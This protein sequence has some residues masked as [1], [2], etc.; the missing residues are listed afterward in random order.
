MADQKKLDYDHCNWVVEGIIKSLFSSP[1]LV[2]PGPDGPDDT[3][4][5][6][7]GRYVKPGGDIKACECRVVFVF[8][9]D[10]GLALYKK[11]EARKTAAHALRGR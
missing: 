3:A 10:R 8:Q 11:W 1:L 9:S 2:A 6:L 7:D 4:E 5:L